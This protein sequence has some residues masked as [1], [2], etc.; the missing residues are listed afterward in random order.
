MI[1]GMFALDRRRSDKEMK[2]HH[3]TA[4]RRTLKVVGII[5]AIPLLAI[6]VVMF[7]YGMFVPVIVA[8]PFFF[9]GVILIIAGSLAIWGFF[10]GANKYRKLEESI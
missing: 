7:V 6:G 1:F 3:E 5:I 4:K 10:R 9:L 2:V 8:G